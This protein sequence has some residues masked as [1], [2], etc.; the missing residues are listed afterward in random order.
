MHHRKHIFLHLEE[1][2]DQPQQQQNLPAVSQETRAAAEE[3]IA[4]EP[5]LAESALEDKGES[6]EVLDRSKDIQGDYVVDWNWCLDK[7]NVSCSASGFLFSTT[8]AAKS[9]NSKFVDHLKI[10]K[11]QRANK[12]QCAPGGGVFFQSS[13]KS[14]IMTN[15]L[16][17]LHYVKA[18]VQV[19]HVSPMHMAPSS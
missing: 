2:E 6:A 18:E 19:S 17:Y 8:K 7:D 11:L 3:R 4:P 12:E 15:L 13:S 1:F 5:G 10:E 16:L 9:L 14:L